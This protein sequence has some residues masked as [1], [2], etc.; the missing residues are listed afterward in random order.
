VPEQLLWPNELPGQ[1]GAGPVMAGTIEVL[2]AGQ[3]G[4]DWREL[5]ASARERADLVDLTLG[6]VIGVGDGQLLAAAASRGCRV[7]VMISDYESLHLGIAEQEASGDETSLM[8]WP[9]STAELD[10]VVQLLKPHLE[11]GELELR[12]FVGAGAYRLLIFDDQA[13]VRLRLPGIADR[14]AMPL[15]YLTRRSAGETFDRFSEHFEA[16]WQTGNA[17]T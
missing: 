7:R 9:A 14:D 5:L 1:D 2:G 15:L 6:D 17:L 16:L 3:D 8:S 12:T 4:T 13:L 10:R 11:R